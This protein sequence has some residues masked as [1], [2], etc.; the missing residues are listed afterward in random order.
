[1]A[2]SRFVFVVR[3]VLALVWFYN[4]FWDKILAG[5]PNSNFAHALGNAFPQQAP[6]TTLHVI[7]WTETL[8]AVIILSGLFHRLISW[9]QLL[10]LLCIGVMGLLTSAARN[11]GAMIITNLPLVMCMLMVAFYGPGWAAIQFNKRKG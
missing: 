1:M 5:D 4:G 7:G 9:L 6:I 10:I 2:N 8:F 3:A 11:P